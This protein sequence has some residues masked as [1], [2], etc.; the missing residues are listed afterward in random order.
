MNDERLDRIIENNLAGAQN[1]RVEISIAIP[2]QGPHCKVTGMLR[3]EALR[4]KDTYLK[5]HG[6]IC[7]IKPCKR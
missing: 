4:L 7:E 1:D 3:C 5:T 2:G 6:Y